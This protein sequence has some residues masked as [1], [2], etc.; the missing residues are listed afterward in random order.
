MDFVCPLTLGFFSVH[1]LFMLLQ[2]SFFYFMLFIL[3]LLVFWV[4]FS[5]LSKSLARKSL[6]VKPV[7]SQGDYLHKRQLEECT[8]CCLLSP[9]PNDVYQFEMTMP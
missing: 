8:I 1:F 4:V 9:T 5:V 3:C 6:L 7:A 2:G